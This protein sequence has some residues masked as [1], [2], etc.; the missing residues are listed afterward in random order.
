[1]DANFDTNFLKQDC[2]HRDSI[3]PL[4]VARGT[5]IVH[6][7][8]AQLSVYGHIQFCVNDSV[9]VQYIY[10]DSSIAQMVF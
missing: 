1:M 8:L 7:L 6:K 4:A 2:I 3:S 9:H 5:I 10:D